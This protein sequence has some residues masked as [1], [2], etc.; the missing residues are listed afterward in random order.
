MM[1]S[2]KPEVILPYAHNLEIIETVYFI[3][4]YLVQ[5]LTIQFGLIVILWFFSLQYWDYRC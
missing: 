4:M 1:F 5:V 3:L 2:S